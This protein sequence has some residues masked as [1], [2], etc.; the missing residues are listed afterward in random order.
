M[1]LLAHFRGVPGHTVEL[2]SVCMDRS[3][4]C[5][6]FAEA[7]PKPSRENASWLQERPSTG[8]RLCGRKSSADTKGRAEGG[9]GGAP[10]AGAQ[11]PLQPIENTM[12]RKMCP[13]GRDPPPG[14]AR[15]QQQSR[16]MAKGGCDLRGSPKDSFWSHLGRTVSHRM[17]PPL[18]ESEESSPQG[19]RSG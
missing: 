17:E 15:D 8:T 5:G 12:V 3:G 19:G 11:I 7:F 14:P 13:W 9:T 4:F 18:E 1:K 6:Q 10:G 2:Y 16:W